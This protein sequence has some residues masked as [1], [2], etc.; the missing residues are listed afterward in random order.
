MERAV[1]VI[2][3]GTGADGTLGI[4]AVKSKGGLVIAQDIGEDDYDGMPRSA[5]A[6]G[7]VDLVLRAATIAVFYLHSPRFEPLTKSQ[8]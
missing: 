6:T 2:L 4:K 1:C 7:A 3:C 8:T 5:V